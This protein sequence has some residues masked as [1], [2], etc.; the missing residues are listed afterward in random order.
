MFGYIL[1]EK[2]ELKLKEY[3][4]Y[5]SIYC[6][7]CKGIRK[8]SGNLQRLLLQYD[9][10]FLAIVIAVAYGKRFDF[11]KG[12]CLLHPA[13]KRMFAD[14]NIIIDYASDMNVILAYYNIRDKWLDDRSAKAL[15]AEILMKPSFK[16]LKAKYKRK[17]EYIE[18]QLK[19]LDR[20]EKGQ[21]R[22]IDEAAHPFSLIMTEIMCDQAL[23]NKLSDIGKKREDVLAMLK[24]IGYNTGKWLYTIDAFDDIEKD[25][26][27]G[28]YNPF[29]RQF[30][31][32]KGLD[33]DCFIAKLKDR[34]DYLLTSCLERIGKAYE[35]FDKNALS[36]ILGNI[37]YM[38]ML[39]R[40]EEVLERKKNTECKTTLNRK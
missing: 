17:C 40:T 36:S 16:K 26:V 24:E 38:G 11:I 34:A 5:R 7:V 27:K 28:S 6:S 13:K 25:A 8:N 23:H 21:G 20:I 30:D 10:A 9:S 12:K 31:Y 14:S 4:I 2:P 15:T 18:N 39:S 35:L 33:M 3:E 19:E 29:L 22:S 1:P 37:I 32:E